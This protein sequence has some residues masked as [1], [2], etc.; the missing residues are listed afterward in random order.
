MPAVPCS[1]K[2]KRKRKKEGGKRCTQTRSK[3]NGA[4]AC[5]SKLCTKSK[6][7]FWKHKQ[8]K[9]IEIEVVVGDG[10]ECGSGILGGKG[11]S[12]VMA[13]H[14]VQSREIEQRPCSPPPLL[15]PFTILSSPLLFSL[16]S[17]FCL[18]FSLQMPNVKLSRI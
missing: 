18:L 8:K 11:I 17:I 3:S 5:L 10:V 4:R 15:S 7:R 14:S 2:K 1:K 12:R 9:K 6:T 13:I 16:I